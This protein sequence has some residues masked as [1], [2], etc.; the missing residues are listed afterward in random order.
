M[1]NP[2]TGFPTD[3]PRDGRA[4][5]F[6]CY[7]YLTISDASGCNFQSVWLQPLGSTPSLSDLPGSIRSCEARHNSDPGVLYL[8]T[9]TSSLEVLV[10]FSSLQDLF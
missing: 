7:W 9:Q 2:Y 1:T 5:A 3:S 6:G 8:L 10:T 4:R